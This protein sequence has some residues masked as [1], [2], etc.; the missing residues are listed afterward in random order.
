MPCITISRLSYTSGR[1][2][3]HNLATHLGYESVEQDVFQDAAAQSG[4]PEAKLV[5]AL[6]DPPSFFGISNVARKRAI[7]YVAAALAKRMLS[8]NLVYHGPFGHILIPGVSHVLKVRIF[9]QR[10]D[11][12]AAKAKRE[13]VASAGEVEKALLREDKQRVALSRLVFN[14][15]DDDANLFDLVINTSQVDAGT[16]V[17][18]IASTV[19]LKR[20]QP[21]TYSVRCMENLE[22]SLRIRAGLID[23]D[24]D[25][26]V[27]ADNG[28]VRIKTRAGGGSK[29]LAEMR[30]QAATLEGVKSLEV[31][32]VDDSFGRIAGGLR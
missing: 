1:A 12:V 17:E 8:D 30:Q 27:E 26:V 23:H 22:L 28:N 2:I 9:A 7:A 18:I 11:R 15:D 25:L 4:V 31:E 21:M 6:R 10:E 14:V 3:A 20:Y 5:R 29:K 32:A 24:P 16:A 13:G 19:K